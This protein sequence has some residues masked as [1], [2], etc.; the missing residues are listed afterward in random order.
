MSDTEQVLACLHADALL[1]KSRL[2]LKQGMHEAAS[3]ASARQQ[4]L[5]ATLQKRDQQADI[6]GA[7]TRK[8]RRLDAVAVEGAGQLPQS[9]PVSAV[10]TERAVAAV[11]AAGD[12]MAGHACLGLVE[13]HTDGQSC[14]MLCVAGC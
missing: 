10:K 14:V 8:E 11:A 4:R 7:R 3:K 6:F 13:A 2:H 5:Q 1:L 9:A 12:A